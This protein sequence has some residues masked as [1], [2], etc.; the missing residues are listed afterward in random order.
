MYKVFSIDSS[1]LICPGVEVSGI[2]YVNKKIKPAIILGNQ[3]I[4]VVPVKL[5]EEMLIKWEDRKK[6]HIFSADFIESKKIIALNPETVVS[7]SEAIVIIKSKAPQ[8]GQKLQGG[9]PYQQKFPGQIINYGTSIAKPTGFGKSQQIISLIAK[10]RVFSIFY[11]G[12][13]KNPNPKY[14]KFNGNELIIV[15]GLKE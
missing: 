13:C 1:D 10:D 11:N 5:T 9:Y 15:N 4:G 2:K 12:I 6:F 14:Y 8:K 3:A 7:K